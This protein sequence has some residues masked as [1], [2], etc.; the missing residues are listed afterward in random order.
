MKDEIIKI[1]HNIIEHNIYKQRTIIKQKK[2]IFCSA[3]LIL[4]I[5]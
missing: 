5:L 2:I 4:K 3:E 1:N